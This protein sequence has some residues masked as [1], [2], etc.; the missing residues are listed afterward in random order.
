MSEDKRYNVP[1]GF[2]LDTL[3]RM[4]KR[5]DELETMIKRV[6]NNVDYYTDPYQNMDN[7]E[8]VEAIADAVGLEFCEECECYCI[9]HASE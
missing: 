5:I 3:K 1:V 7:Y 6:Q 2:S 9:K 4:E 8:F